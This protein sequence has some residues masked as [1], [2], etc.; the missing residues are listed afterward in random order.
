M[1]NFHEEFD[2][3]TSHLEYLKDRHRSL[4]NHIKET[5]NNMNISDEVRKLKTQK[6]WIKDEIYRIETR[7]KEIQPNGHE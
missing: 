5:F 1:S 2:K 6:L 7:I 3:L 4:D